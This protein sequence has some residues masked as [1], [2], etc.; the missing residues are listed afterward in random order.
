MAQ[1]P[2]CHTCYRDLFVPKCARCGLGIEGDGVSVGSFHYHLPCARCSAPDCKSIDTEEL[3]LAPMQTESKAK[4]PLPP[5]PPSAASAAGKAPLP[6]SELFCEKHYLE[7]FAERCE[8]C[9]LPCSGSVFQVDGCTYHEACFACTTCKVSLVAGSG[10]QTFTLRS[11]ASRSDG[12]TTR[13]HLYC[14]TH[15]LTAKLAAASRHPSI[16]RTSATPSAAA[17]AATP[18]AAPTAAAAAATAPAAAPAAAS[19][20]AAAAAPSGSDAAA[21]CAVCRKAITDEHL[22]HNGKLYHLECVVCK[23]CGETL[24]T[25]MDRSLADPVCLLRGAALYFFVCLCF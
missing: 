18:A 21:A 20:A 12:R 15:Y 23:C 11:A 13:N 5:P 3:M 4:P 2:Y 24:H 14:R 9:D 7:A 16:I 17:A 6:G 10:Q 1:Y 22:N 8:K 25:G 19:A